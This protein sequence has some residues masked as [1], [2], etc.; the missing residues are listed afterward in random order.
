[1]GERSLDRR[2]KPTMN[3]TVH[4]IRNTKPASRSA[5]PELNQRFAT[6]E[7]MVRELRESM[8]ADSAV[9]L[10]GRAARAAAVVDLLNVQGAV[11]VNDVKKSL[12]VTMKTANRL[13]HHV[14]HCGAGVLIEEPLGGTDRLVLFH[15]DR[16]VI[17]D[18][19]K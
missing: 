4:E 6:L 9:I 16:V 19:R 10:Q 12:G 5:L 1:M 8:A 14:S 7:K 18:P 17:D 3:A 13:L 11:T 2:R 15:P